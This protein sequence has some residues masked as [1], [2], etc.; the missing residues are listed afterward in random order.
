MINPVF[1]Q[2]WVDGDR[3]QILLHFGV[4]LARRLLWS[5]TRDTCIS[6]GIYSLRR[7]F[8]SCSLTDRMKCKM[9]K[10]LKKISSPLCEYTQGSGFKTGQLFAM[11]TTALANACA[12]VAWKYTKETLCAHVAAHNSCAMASSAFCLFK[13]WDEG[14]TVCQFL[15]DALNCLSILLDTQSSSG[16]DVIVIKCYAIGN[17]LVF[18]R[19]L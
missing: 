2:R 11:H 7:N 8:V 18:L 13:K 1:A 9:A 6:G 17:W 15:L 16:A 3:E 19:T 10:N 12:D 4:L 14:Q 5:L